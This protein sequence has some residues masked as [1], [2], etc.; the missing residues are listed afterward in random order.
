MQVTS[1]R[2]TSSDQNLLVIRNISLLDL[3]PEG[4]RVLRWCQRRTRGGES[5]NVTVRTRTELLGAGHISVTDAHEVLVGRVDSDR[6]HVGVNGLAEEVNGAISEAE[7]CAAG[8]VAAEGDSSL[9]AGCCGV[10]HGGPTA[11]DGNEPLIGAGAIRTDRGSGGVIVTGG[12]HG[13]GP[14][15]LT[16]LM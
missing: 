14:N 7:I 13:S 12:K 4:S 5:K 6:C 3:T 15:A 16:L 10:D 9:A 8:V 2:T 11:E 1:D